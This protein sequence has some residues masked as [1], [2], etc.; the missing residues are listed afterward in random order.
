MTTPSDKSRGCATTFRC[1]G[2][3]CYLGFYPLLRLWRRPAPH[4]F[5]AH[6]C[7]QAMAAGFVALVWLLVDAL[8]EAGETFL[9]IRFPEFAR[10]FIDQ[11]EPYL[12]YALLLPLILLGGLWLVSFGLA[13]AGST[14]PVP[15]LKRVARW[16]GAVRLSLAAS[17][18]VL[19]LL[20]IVV[21]L[22]VHATSRTRTTGEGAALYFLYDEGI[23]VPRWGYALGLYRVSLEADRRWGKGSTVL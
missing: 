6:H 17:S 12:T 22:A 18:L 13:L 11:W 3:A 8:F 21:L 9:L 10:P 1:S 7:A 2:A 19:T 15:V 23:P 20:P 5:V 4:T 14:R 16:R